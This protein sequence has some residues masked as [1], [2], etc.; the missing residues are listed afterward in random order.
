MRYPLDYIYITQGYRANPNQLGYSDFGHTG[1]DLR[2]PIGTDVFSPAKGTVKLVNN[3][4]NYLGGK[5]AI[6]N[7]GGYDFYVGHLSKVLV[8]AGQKVKEGQ[9]I[10]ESGNTSSSK[11]SPH[12]H[13]QVRKN[14]TLVNPTKIGLKKIVSG[15]IKDM[16]KHSFNGKI[17]NLSA[18]GWFAKAVH[19][20]KEYKKKVKKLKTLNKQLASVET[21]V[22][23]LNKSVA[24]LKSTNVQ[25]KDRLTA[26]IN[27]LQKDLGSANKKIAEDDDTNEKVTSIFNYFY[28]RWATFRDFI[29]RNKE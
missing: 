19:W 24:A 7:G 26:Q 20:L 21:K 10:A 18:K 6:I 16:Y 27:E 5:Y 9:H 1:I 14:G 11:I 22:S 12:L 2:A 3:D 17:F 28:D 8:R 4:P 29:T 23:N 15:T 25:E 13:F